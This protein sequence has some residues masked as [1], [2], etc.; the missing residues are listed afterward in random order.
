LLLLLSL[1]LL[2]L[3]A[4]SDGAACF[5]IGL[6]P[7]LCVQPLQDGRDEDATA[8]IQLLAPTGVVLQ[9]IAVCVA[10]AQQTSRPLYRSSI[11]ATLLA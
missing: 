3:A 11:L 10:D 4:G 7:V 5:T 2:L 1:L 9:S 8:L 6:M